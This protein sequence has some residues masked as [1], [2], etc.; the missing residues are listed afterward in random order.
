M[1]MKSILAA[2][3]VAATLAVAAP[4]EAHHHHKL[5]IGLGIN[6]GDPGYYPDY[7]PGYYDPPPPPPRYV[8]RPRPVYVEPDYGYDQEDYGVSCGQGRRIVRNSGF[9]NVSTI[10][11]DGQN[12]KYEAERRGRT[13]IVKLDSRTGEIIQANRY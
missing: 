3:A 6:L 9:Y 11:C 2:T 7:N 5:H 8:P 4:A 12:F 1:I 13:Y 10:E